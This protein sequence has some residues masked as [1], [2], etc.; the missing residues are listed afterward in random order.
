M[1]APCLAPTHCPKCGERGSSSMLAC[2]AS[3]VEFGYHH[4][5]DS[6][7]WNGGGLI[8]PAEPMLSILDA[9]Y[10]AMWRA[11]AKKVAA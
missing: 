5:P 4:L 8:V 3:P 9:C 11:R 10:E 7:R 6:T 2:P 1:S